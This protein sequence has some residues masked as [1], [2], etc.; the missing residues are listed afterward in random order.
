MANSATTSVSSVITALA[1]PPTR[2]MDTPALDYF[3]I[4]VVNTIRESTAVAVART[5]KLEQ[6]MVEAGLLPPPAN[7]PSNAVSSKRESTVRDS[8]GSGI[9]KGDSG[10]LKVA[11]DEEEEALRQ[12]LEAIGMHVG[13]NVAERC[14][15]LSLRS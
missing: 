12:R 3:L 13:A 6:E 1:D 4:E 8:V 10:L 7:T 11:G 15:L 5:K 2:L 14:V 9:S